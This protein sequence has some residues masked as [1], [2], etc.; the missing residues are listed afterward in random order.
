MPNLNYKRSRA[1]EYQVFHELEKEGWM[2]IR[3]AGSHG[4][5]DI[6]G[7]RPVDCS[8]PSHFEVKFI[9]I[10]V[11]IGLKNK[12]K[13]PKVVESPCGMI[14]VEFWKFPVKG[15]AKKSKTKMGKRKSKSRT[16]S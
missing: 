9:Q 8:D 16:H 10:K 6:I 15:Y 4:V 11:S 13:E 14:N 2:A 12:H 7:I 5:A 1:R 3:S